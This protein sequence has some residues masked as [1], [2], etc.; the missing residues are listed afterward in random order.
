MNEPPQSDAANG[1]GS[2]SR[3]IWPGIGKGFAHEDLPKHLF[4]VAAM[5]ARRALAAAENDRDQLDRATSIGTAVE[6]LAKAALA[7]ISPTLIA[8]KD[9]KSSLLY[10]GVPVMSPHEAKS[11]AATDCLLILKQ[12]HS[13]DFNPQTDSKVFLVRN[14]ALHMGQVD[15]TLFQEALSIMTR[16][17]EALLAV[18]KHY[19]SSPVLDRTNFW[20]RHLLA[21]VDER[22]K[23][24]QEGR[25]LELLELKEAARQRFDRLQSQGLDDNALYEIADDDPQLDDF[26]VWNI[27]FDAPDS[28]PE[29]PQCP[30][31]YRSG[32]LGYDLINR[33]SI[34]METDE[35]HV[36][37]FVDITIQAGRF[38]CQVCGL[39]LHSELL[40][41]EGMDD[42]RVI[43]VEATQEEIDSLE[44][45]QID[46]YLE[47]LYRDGDDDRDG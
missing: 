30:V 28:K 25:M 10:S 31:C 12:S 16:L 36:S 42:V 47:E 35:D 8:E 45:Y 22:L 40:R 29:R 39:R 46:S 37:Y 38:L 3:T 1:K 24:E 5:H 13:I 27:L 17:N 20:G 11:K 2:E 4:T 19:D 9:P 21:Q 14:F 43:R 41:L 18:I 7:L 15:P 23:K 34:Y 32:W 33:G 6:L 26:E 44:A